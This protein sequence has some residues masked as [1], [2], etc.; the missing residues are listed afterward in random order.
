MVAGSTT[1]HFYLSVQAPLKFIRAI[2]PSSAHTS[3][4][5]YCKQ[6][7]KTSEKLVTLLHPQHSKPLLYYSNHV[8]I[9]THCR[10]YYQY[11]K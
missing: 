10:Y 5:G 8:L 11:S 1:S 2:P 3:A 7:L 6:D 9:L 4:G